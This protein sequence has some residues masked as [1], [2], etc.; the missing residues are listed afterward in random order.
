MENE[1]AL[2]RALGD[3]T[4]LRIAVILAARGETCVCHIAT[5]LEAPDFKV[6]RHLSVLRASG[7]V[8]ARREGTW[9]HYSLT[10][11]EG[12]LGGSLR[13]LLAEGF[14]GNET[15]RLDRERLSGS[16]CA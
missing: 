14:S 13:R 9:M 8:S 10:P 5:A 4:R 7:L 15:A 16:C 2:F 6:S 11:P 3:P 12:A 1:A